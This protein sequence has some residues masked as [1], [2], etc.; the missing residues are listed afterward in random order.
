MLTPWI[1]WAIFP[2][3]AGDPAEEVTLVSADGRRPVVLVVDDYED[4]RRVLS[5][6]LRHLGYDVLLAATGREALEVFRRH[7]PNIDLILMDI[8]MPDGDGPQTLDLLRRL[9]PDVR[10]CL[11]TGDPGSYTPDEL[12]RRGAARVL[13]KPLALAELAD[14]LKQVLK[15]PPPIMPRAA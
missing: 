12:L 1:D 14:V 4:L 5:Q 7:G 2:A 8:L 10:C 6:A 11:M 15:E 3:G 13:A 9:D